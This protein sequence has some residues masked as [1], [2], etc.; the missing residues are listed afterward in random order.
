MT[1]LAAN[2]IGV[3]SQVF[4]YDCPDDSGEF[5]ED[6]V[7]NPTLIMFG[8]DTAGCT[9]RSRSVQLDAFDELPYGDHVQEGVAAHNAAS[10]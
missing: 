4:I 10:P 2:Q 9:K 6:V 3:G 7:V 8:W 5:R 1:T